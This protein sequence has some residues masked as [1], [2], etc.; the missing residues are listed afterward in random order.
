MS[1]QPLKSLRAMLGFALTAGVANKGNC[2][3][4]TSRLDVEADTLSG[5]GGGG[6]VKLE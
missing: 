6:G 3:L 4:L 5:G 2:W 1:R